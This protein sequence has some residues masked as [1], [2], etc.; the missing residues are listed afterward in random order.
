[1]SLGVYVMSND[2][3]HIDYYL[4][5]MIGIVHIGL[6]FYISIRGAIEILKLEPDNRINLWKKLCDWLKT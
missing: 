4:K 6:G 5:N 1:M 2:V 3:T